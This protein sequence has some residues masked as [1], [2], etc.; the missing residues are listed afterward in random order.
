MKEIV[1]GI[2]FVTGSKDIKVTFDN[3]S[4]VI[5]TS[6]SRIY[7]KKIVGKGDIVI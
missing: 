4:Y 3:G 1:A 5:L 2:Q 6:E 7:I